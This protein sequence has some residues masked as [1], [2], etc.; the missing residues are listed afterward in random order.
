MKNDNNDNN[1]DKTLKDLEIDELLESIKSG[2]VFSLEEPKPKLS[3]RTNNV[4]VQEE[5]KVEKKPSK[6]KKSKSTDKPQKSKKTKKTKGQ[7]KFFE[8]IKALPKSVKL[9]VLII[10]LIT[11][12]IIVVVNVVSYFQSAYLKPYEKKYNMTFPKGIAEEFCDEYAKNRLLAG[13]LDIADT[14]SEIYVADNEEVINAHAEIGTDLMSDQQFKAIY[15]NKRDVDLESKFKD[16]DS[17]IKSSQKVEFTDI[18]GNTTVYQILGAYYVT[19]RPQDDNNYLF[20]YNLYGDLTEN[21]FDDYKDRINSRLLYRTGYNLSYFDKFLTLSVESD[22]MSGF[23]FVVLCKQAEDDFTPFTEVTPNE[24]VHYP[25]IWYDVNKKDNTY[26]F[27][28][29][30]Y[31]TIYTDEKH[32]ETQSLK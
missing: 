26:R 16:P 12:A 27:A 20:M 3:E 30:W 5:A 32:S 9:G 8:K 18:Y 23:R 29:K 15:L 19:T 28:S 14:D 13:R 7:N 24:R 11:A 6:A 21:S 1:L 25:Q 4:K 2:S 10:V 22:F 17:Y 31:P